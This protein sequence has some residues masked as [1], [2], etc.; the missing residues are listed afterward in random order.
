[1]EAVAYGRKKYSFKD[2]NSKVQKGESVGGSRA[3]L[4]TIIFLGSQAPSDHRLIAT[5]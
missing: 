2:D 5:I 1:M 3:R 4:A